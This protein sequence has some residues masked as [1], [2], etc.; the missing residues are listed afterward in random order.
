M[1]TDLAKPCDNC[2]FRNNGKGVKLNRSRITELAQRVGVEGRGFICHKTA[3]YED[4]PRK[5]EQHC[6][7]ALAFTRNVGDET[8]QIVLRIRLDSNETKLANVE[9]NRRDVYQTTD[10]WLERGSL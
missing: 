6:A 9:A 4:E 3:N 2:P 10:E 8:A 1:K 7:G 5:Q